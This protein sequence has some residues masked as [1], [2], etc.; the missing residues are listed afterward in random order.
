ME[1]S[2]SLEPGLKKYVIAGARRARVEPLDRRAFFLGRAGRFMPAFLRDAGRGA[3]RAVVFFFARFFA[4]FF[5]VVFREEAGRRVGVLRECFGR[6]V[7]MVGVDS[8]AWR[9]RRTAGRAR[10]DP[11]A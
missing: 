3:E 1:P 10:V 8:S 4:V 9:V 2:P 6:D 11:G 7:G 5:V